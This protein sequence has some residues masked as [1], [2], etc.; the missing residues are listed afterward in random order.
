MPNKKNTA[1]KTTVKKSSLTLSQKETKDLASKAQKEMKRLGFKTIEE[2]IAYI[3]K[4][5]GY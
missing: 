3:D 4:K 2:Y 5:R 1:K